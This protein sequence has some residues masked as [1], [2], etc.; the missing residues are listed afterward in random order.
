MPYHLTEKKNPAINC[1]RC[2]HDISEAHNY[3]ECDTCFNNFHLKCEGILGVNIS[4][5]SLAETYECKDCKTKTPKR[6][7]DELSP[8]QSQN[9]RINS[10]TTPKQPEKKQTEF[11]E[12][13]AL[14]LQIQK[15]NNDMRE[16]QNGLATTLNQIKTNQTSLSQKFDDMRSQINDLTLEHKSFKEDINHIQ[17]QHHEQSQII[18][19][20]EADNDALQQ[21]NL[22]N[23]LIIGGLPN[24]VDAR[25]VL[26]KIMNV[27]DTQ[28]SMNDVQDIYYLHTKNIQQSETSAQNENNKKKSPLLLVKFKNFESKSEMVQKR[29]KKQTLFVNEIELNTNNDTQIYFRDHVTPFKNTLFK[30]CR[31]LKDE[32]TFK[33]LWMRD[34][35]ILLRK[36]ENSK[37]YSISSRNDIIKIKSIYCNK[38]QSLAQP[39]EISDK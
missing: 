5:I 4:R 34:T 6:G 15:L 26:E 38:T 39:Q 7:S 36:Q 16:P 32:L 31:E 13:K 33:F 27:L 29:K 24:N 3:T 23:N 30:E 35:Q 12:L 19:K 28:C 1:G 2:Q 11:G 21:K 17:K 14:I 18:N 25:V 8:T 20:L 22:Q 37:I 10:Q 9:K